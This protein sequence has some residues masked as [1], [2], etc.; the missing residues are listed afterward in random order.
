M[1][2]QL[3][4]RIEENKETKIIRLPFNQDPASVPANP[5]AT[6]TRR[7]SARFNFTQKGLIKKI[8]TNTTI[9]RDREIK[10]RRSKDENNPVIYKRPMGPFVLLG[11]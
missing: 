3:N 9:S 10:G 6:F 11:P 8:P 1:P 7:Y 2:N 5:S 4:Q